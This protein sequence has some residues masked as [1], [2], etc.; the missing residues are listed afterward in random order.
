MMITDLGE[1][2]VDRGTQ[3][4][5]VA[6]SNFLKG[7]TRVFATLFGQNLLLFVYILW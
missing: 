5:D 3:W 2:D 4:E 6:L 1:G 7:H